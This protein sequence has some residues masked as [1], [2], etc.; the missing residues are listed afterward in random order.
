M[1][2]CSAVNAFFLGKSFTP[3]QTDWADLPLKKY[4]NTSVEEQQKLKQ[5]NINTSKIGL[6]AR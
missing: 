3:L 1:L 4:H 6:T 5:Q 2:S